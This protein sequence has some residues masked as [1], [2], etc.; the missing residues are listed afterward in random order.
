MPFS[1]QQALCFCDEN[2]QG[3]TSWQSYLVS[4]LFWVVI[5]NDSYMLSKIYPVT[6][7]KLLIELS[8]Q[9][10]QNKDEQSRY[11][12]SIQGINELKL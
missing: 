5:H 2:K 7:L 9:G 3:F 12:P 11:N 4:P 6:Q 8:I 1:A 10:P